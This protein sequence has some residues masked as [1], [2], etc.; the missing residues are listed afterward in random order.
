MDKLMT[1]RTL[2]KQQLSE[3]ATLL[4][5]QHPPTDTGVLAQCVFDEAREQYLLL[6]VG[7]DGQHRI[8]CTTL[9]VR[10][11]NDKVW[12]EEDMTEEGIATA[13]VQAGVPKTDIVL[14]F[15][16]PE[17]RRFTEFATA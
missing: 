10:L 14:A 4:N 12:I 1:Y 11:L 17:T 6:K 15:Q 13:L 3:L 16:P 2:I 8:R 9:Y 5:T 7:W